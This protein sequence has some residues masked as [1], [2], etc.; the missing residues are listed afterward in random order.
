M[1]IPCFLQPF[2]WNIQRLQSLAPGW[3]HG[4][5][6]HLRQR[7]AL[8]AADVDQSR[9][10]PSGAQGENAAGNMGKGRQDILLV[11]EYIYTYIIINI[12]IYIQL[13]KIWILIG[14]HW[15]TLVHIG[16]QVLCHW[17]IMFL[18][19]FKPYLGAWSHMTNQ[20]RKMC[21][22]VCGVTAFAAGCRLMTYDITYTYIAYV[23]VACACTCNFDM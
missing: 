2:L 17:L 6:R 22:C 10:R 15:V 1:T 5:C 19:V 13:Y 9:V 21:V 7:R 4:H 12:Y 20:C 16:F 23:C 3:Q 18:F 14:S 8:R 11:D